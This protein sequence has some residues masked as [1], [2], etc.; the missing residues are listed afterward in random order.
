MISGLYTAASGLIAQT[1]Q[2]D[3]IA[4]NLSVK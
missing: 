4:N 1:E 2:Q 3:V